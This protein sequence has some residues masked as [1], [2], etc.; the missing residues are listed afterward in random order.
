MPYA[1]IDTVWSPER[2]PEEHVRWR[3]M[4]FLK[5]LA[6]RPED[7][8]AVVTHSSFMKH[9]F[10]IFAGETSPSVDED[11]DVLRAVPAN[12]ELRTVVLCHH[13]DS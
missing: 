4:L 3:A 6:D 8:V 2:E 5:W 7:E 9:M 13:G 10:A 11:R 12:C 1:D